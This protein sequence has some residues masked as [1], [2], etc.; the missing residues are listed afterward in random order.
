MPRHSAPAVYN[1]DEQPGCV[2]RAK[3]RISGSIIGLYHV[4]QAGLDESQGSWAAKCETH[5]I[6]KYCTASLNAKMSLSD[7]TE[8]CAQCEKAGQERNGHR[9]AS[10]AS[11]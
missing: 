6:T 11:S 5:G 1:F 4:K 8:W 9:V 3:N 10:Q 7:P 2:V